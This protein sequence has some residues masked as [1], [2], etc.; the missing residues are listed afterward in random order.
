VLD[1]QM[2][3]KNGKLPTAGHDGHRELAQVWRDVGEDDSVRVPGCTSRAGAAAAAPPRV[4]STN[5]ETS[6]AEADWRASPRPQAASAA[7]TNRLGRIGNRM[8][9]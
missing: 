5:C 3:A 6:C 4:S 7:A 9:I 8:R 1:I 2:R